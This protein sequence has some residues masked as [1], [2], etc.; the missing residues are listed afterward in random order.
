MS[1][2]PQDHGLEQESAV[3]VQYNSVYEKLVLHEKDAVGL[4]AYGI[5]KKKKVTLCREY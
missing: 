3:G 1:D 2:M 5:Y 4:V